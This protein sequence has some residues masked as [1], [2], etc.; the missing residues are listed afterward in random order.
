MVAMD[1]SLD[2]D[3]DV[4]MMDESVRKPTFAVKS[5]RRFRSRLLKVPGRVKEWGVV[6]EM[7]EP[8]ETTT[9][10]TQ[11]GQVQDEGLQEGRRQQDEPLGTNGHDI[12]SI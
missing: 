12:F 4:T 5:R 11:A 8:G 10:V 7:T 1:G 3:G 6:M 9:V 2:L